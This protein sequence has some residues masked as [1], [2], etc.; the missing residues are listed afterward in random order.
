[1]S[2]I[3]KRAII[4]FAIP[5][6]V[7]LI[8]TVLL[9]LADADL[10]LAQLFYS[11][12]KGWLWKD[13]QPWDFLYR[14]G[15]ILPIAL[16]VSGFLMATYS[17]FSHKLVHWKNAFVFLAVLMILG[18]G[19]LVNAVFKDHWGRPR[20]A[21]V[22]TFGGTQKYLPVWERGNAG[23]DKSFPCGHASAGFFL[24]APFFFLRKTSPKWAW[25]FLWVG[26]IYGVVMGIG[27]MAQGGHFATDVLW[28]GGMVYLLGLVLSYLFRFDNSGPLF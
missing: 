20:P 21:E 6:G 18:P 11:S 1:M 12:E 9:S 7:L 26:M 2:K 24:F 4:D 5:I 23:Q 14:Y 16:A 27:R 10:R 8:L 22:E 13:I 19:I 3:K 15:T 28:A 25:V 17:M